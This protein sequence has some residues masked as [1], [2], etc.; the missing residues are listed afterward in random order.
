VAPGAE[1]AAYAEAPVTDPRG[2]YRFLSLIG[3][4]GVILSVAALATP[5]STAMSGGDRRIYTSAT[6]PLAKLR[7]RL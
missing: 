3:Q 4:K 7:P 2:Q 5:A 1:A 6:I